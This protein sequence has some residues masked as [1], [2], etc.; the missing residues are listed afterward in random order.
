MRR[1]ILFS[2]VIHLLTIGP[3]GWAQEPAQLEETPPAA[4]SAQPPSEEKPAEEPPQA[5]AQEPVKPTEQAPPAEVH[6]P[7][8][9]PSEEKPKEKEAEKALKAEEERRPISPEVEREG[10]IP[11]KGR[12]QLELVETYAHL[13]SNQLFIEGFGILPILVVGQ[14]EV[15]RIRRDTF[16]TTLVGRY[17]LMEGLQVELRVPYQFTSI[18][19]STPTGIMGRTEATPNVEESSTSTGLGDVSGSLIYQLLKEGFRRPG[20]VVGLGFKG[21]TGRDVFQTEDPSS[22]PP[23]GSGFNSV[24]LSLSVTKTSDPAV[25]F[26][27]VSYAYALSRKNVVYRPLNRE[28]TLIDFDPGDNFG[29]GMGIAYALNYKLTL[30]T[31]YQQSINFST[32]INGNKLPNSSTNAISLRLGVVWRINDR[33]SI[34]LSVSPGLTLD[35]PDV[36]VELR[37]PYRF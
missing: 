7:A 6:P 29:L 30:T 3:M 18:R 36:R 24:S 17:K 15:Q 10:L 35:A 9:P 13:S 23:T 31:Q 11:I 2:L 5:P 32:R 37:L 26:G 22:N 25:L 34:D 27:F 8:H 33:M 12:L 16:I 4:E 28:P 20:L 21:R 1:I 19:I 14:V